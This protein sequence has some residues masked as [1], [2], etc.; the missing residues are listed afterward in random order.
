MEERLQ[1]P[2]MLAEQVVQYAR[3]L[4]PKPEVRLKKQVES[5]S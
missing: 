2:G 5:R 3:E 4:N 1:D